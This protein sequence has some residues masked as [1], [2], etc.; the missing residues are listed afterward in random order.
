MTAERIDIGYVTELRSW[1]D[2]PVTVLVHGT[3]LDRGAWDDVGPLVG[4]RRRVVAYD[5]RGHGSAAGVPLCSYD[6]LAADLGRLLDVLGADRAEIVGHS[7][8]GQVVAHAAR[9]MHERVAALTIVCARLIPFA[10]FAD[11]A[12][13]VEAGAIAT[14][15]EGAIGRW[16]T[17]ADVAAQTPAVRYARA[18]LAHADP[19]AFATALRMIASF[20]GAEALVDLE[21]PISIVVAERDAVATEPELHALAERLR[22]G[23]F[24]RVDGAGHMLPIE[25]P[26][27]LAG[28]LAH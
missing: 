20:D 19:A 8:G 23:R 18:A 25:H 6:E 7:F 27:E 4:G 17:E 10:P 2:G 16:F 1:G 3:P 9:A 11:A 15:G 13:A 28:L 12:D 22:R 5:L 14:V 21:I 24:T 26:R